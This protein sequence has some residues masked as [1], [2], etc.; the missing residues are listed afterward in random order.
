MQN[1]DYI[2]F[3]FLYYNNNKLFYGRFDKLLQSLTEN[4]F[5]SQINILYSFH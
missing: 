3:T 4:L 5:S 1:T 2:F